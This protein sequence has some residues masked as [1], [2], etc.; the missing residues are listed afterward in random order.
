MY[1]ILSKIQLPRLIIHAD[2]II[3]N[4]QFVF[5]CNSEIQNM[6][7]AFVKYLRQNWNTVESS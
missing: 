4:H 2:E 6:Y 7:S 5:R 3:G 1:K